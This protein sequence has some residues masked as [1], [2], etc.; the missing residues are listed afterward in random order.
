M[1]KK[2]SPCNEISQDHRRANAT[3]GISEDGAVDRTVYS[4][5]SLSILTAIHTTLQD[6][7]RTAIGAADQAAC[8]V[9]RNRSH[10]PTF[11]L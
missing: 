6:N 9:H 1:I 8:S 10:R 11:R 7:G 5:Y 3:Q 2:T 4:P